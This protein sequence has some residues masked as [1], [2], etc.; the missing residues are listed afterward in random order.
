M[1][2]RASVRFWGLK[3]SYSSIVLVDSGARMSLFD[4]L[5]AEK[6][7]VEYTG[8]E[9]SFTSISGHIVKGLEA[10]VPKIEIEGETLKCEPMVVAEI[11]QKVKEVL[12]S[13]GLDENVIIGVLTLERANMI[14]DTTAGILKKVEG[15]IFTSPI[16]P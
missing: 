1:L 3:S 4:K 14:P 11:P 15:F 2:V 6:L 13:N 5:L 10:I 7:G 9:I 8:R 12:R 16:S